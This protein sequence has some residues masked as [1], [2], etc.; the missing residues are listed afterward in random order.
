M[1]EENFYSE[2]CNPGYGEISHE[3][4]SKHNHPYFKVVTR[5]DMWQLLKKLIHNIGLAFVN[6]TENKIY[7]S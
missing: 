3:A 4:N 7:K 5:S 2:A 1:F 6:I